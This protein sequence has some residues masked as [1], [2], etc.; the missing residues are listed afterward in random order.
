MTTIRLPFVILFLF[1]A[2]LLRAETLYVGGVIEAGIHAAPD[3]AS[4]ILGLLPTGSRVE[5]LE[6][7]ETMLRARTAD[8]V[9]GWMD[10]RLLAESLPGSERVR[11]LENELAGAQAA[12][13]DA[14]ARLVAAEA[15]APGTTPAR[16]DEQAIPSDALREMQLLAEENQRLK[17]EVA[18]LEAMQRMSLEQ[19]RRV[20]EEAA[21]AP[22]T[23]PPGAATP[24][25]L[26]PTRWESWH[27]VLVASVLLLAF[28]TGGWLVDWS[29]RRR[30]GGFRI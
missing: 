20:N 3:I 17:Q 8:G 6:R 7:Q 4:P 30:H 26:A 5:V 14:Q 10:A 22:A 24:R 21:A 18:E 27:L 12:L 29:I 9:E 19:Q 28:S 15:A 23:A 16:D 11:E 25:D 1:F 2:P 13:A